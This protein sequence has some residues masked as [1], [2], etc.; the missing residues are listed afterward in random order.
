MLNGLSGNADIRIVDLSGKLMYND[1]MNCSGNVTSKQYT[2]DHLSKGVYLVQVI[3]K[4]EIIS[5]KLILK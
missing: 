1:Q 4:E 2:L 5:Q 3:N